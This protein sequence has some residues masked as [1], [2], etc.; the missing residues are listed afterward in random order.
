MTVK[1][2]TSNLRKDHLPRY[3]RKGSS[4]KL[5]AFKAHINERLS[6]YN[7]SAKRLYA[8]ILQQGYQGKYSILADYVKD[9]K[10]QH[11]KQA[12]L[13]FETLPG[14]QAQVDWAYMGNFL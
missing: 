13:R 5:D 6:Q 12:F 9:Q 7:L 2:V 3:V 14:E 10:D 1:T 4:S 8:E 11:K